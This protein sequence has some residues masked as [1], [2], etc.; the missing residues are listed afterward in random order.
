MIIWE[1]AIILAFDLSKHNCSR[2]TILKLLINLLLSI[3]SI[4]YSQYFVKL[5]PRFYP[6][7]LYQTG[8]CSKS[9]IS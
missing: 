9:L 4:Y 8:Y 7:L 1:K 3:R 5:S 2:I 6:A